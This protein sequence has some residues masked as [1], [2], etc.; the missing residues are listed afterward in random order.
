MTPSTNITTDERLLG[1]VL[2]C[3]LSD[4]RK[5]AL[6]PWFPRKL[7]CRVKIRYVCLLLLLLLSRFSRVRLCAT[8]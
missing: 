7:V 4:S 5:G 2:E 1:R 8:P 3:E 6:D